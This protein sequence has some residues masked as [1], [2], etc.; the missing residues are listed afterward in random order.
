MQQAVEVEA[1]PMGRASAIC[2][3]AEPDEPSKV[4]SLLQDP[5]VPASKS[6]AELL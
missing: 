3:M 4:G 6:R 1:R 5:Q 2:S